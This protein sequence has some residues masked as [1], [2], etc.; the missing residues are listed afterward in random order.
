MDLLQLK[1]FVKIVEHRSFTKAARD[2][3]VS[4]PALSQQIRKLER[5]LGQPILERK[6]RTVHLTSGGQ[7]LLER[8]ERILKLVAD[9]ESQITDDGETGRLSVSA[10]PTIGPYFLPRLLQQ[11]KPQFP[12]AKFLIGEDVTEVLA[13]RCLNGDIDVG[14][15]ALPSA[16]KRIH[17][18]PLFEEE[19][20]VAFNKDH[21]F[22]DREVITDNDI[23]NETFVLLGETHCLTDAIESY[24]DRQDIQPVSTARI[25]QLETVK[26]L[27]ALGQGISFIPEMAT[28]D[29]LGGRLVY[30]KIKG[31]DLR[32]TIAI[33]WNP[34]RYQSQLF[35]NF[36][37]ALRELAD[38]NVAQPDSRNARSRELASLVSGQSAQKR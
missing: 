38:F 3:N 35:S 11:V 29:D 23:R 10:I 19:L 21:P 15:L 13:Q 20:Y 18:E 14:I 8:A 34:A 37:K 24:C 32:R 9:T 16:T 22:A 28:G 27:V 6:G 36:V 2:C 31:S 25:Q 7:L 12:K 17:I 33:C 4:Q 26:Q 1:Y 30:R 5:Q